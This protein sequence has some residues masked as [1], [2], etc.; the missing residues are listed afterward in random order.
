MTDGAEVSPSEPQ[1]ATSLRW[2]WAHVSGGAPPPVVPTRFGSSVLGV[3][4][5]FD[6]AQVLDRVYLPRR[7]GATDFDALAGDWKAV[8]ADF[9]EALLYITRSFTPEQKSALR[10][11]L[12][13]A[14]RDVGV[15]QLTLFP[16]SGE[17]QSQLPTS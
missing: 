2:Y 8:G 13:I 15:K 4:H 7:Y 14:V 11:A 6:F 16:V 5:L 9:W 17:E 1:A 10:E 12:T 3:A